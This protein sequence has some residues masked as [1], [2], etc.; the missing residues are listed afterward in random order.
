MEP[1]KLPPIAK[2]YEALTAVLDGR[3]VS[4]DAGEADV[5]SSGG[6]KSYRVRWS[7]NGITSSDPSSR[8]HGTLGYPAIAVLLDCG[9]LGFDR[10][11]AAPL[12]GVPWKALNDR[13]RRDYDAAVTHALRQVDR[14]P[15]D[16]LARDIYAQ[17][18]ALRPVK[19]PP[20]S[21]G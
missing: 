14:G 2:V 21:R 6:D 3:V 16:A 20:K 12:A 13:F 9:T 1:W 4:V 15:V 5:S 8:F 17:L 10:L 7:G 11:V 18:E 19:L